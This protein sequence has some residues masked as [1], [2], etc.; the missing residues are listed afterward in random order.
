MAAIETAFRAFQRLRP[1]AQSVQFGFP[2]VDSLKIQERCG[3]GVH[4]LPHGDAR[5]LEQLAGIVLQ[6]V[7]GLFCEFPG[8]PLLAS[9]DLTQ[10]ADLSRRHDFPVLVDDTLEALVNVDVLPQADVVSTSLTKYFSGAGDVMAGS[11]V[12]N[13][14]RPRYQELRE[15]LEAEYEDLLDAEDAAA[16]ER[17]SRDCIERARRINRNAE[18]LCEVLREHPAVAKIEYPK[19]RT[20]EN[21][22]AFQRPDAGYGGL[23]SMLLKNPEQNSPAFSTRWRFPKGRI[24]ERISH[25]AVRTRF[26]RIS[27]NSNSSSAAGFRAICCESRSD[28]KIRNG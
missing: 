7:L 12:L 15:A 19:Y 16:L 5:D 14:C 6:P 28:W 18:A 25:S 2:Y 8:N 17:N 9:P 24:W 4:F 20:P 23:F 3:V 22:R 26:S 10:I 27:T 1:T 11:L 21:Y 13:S